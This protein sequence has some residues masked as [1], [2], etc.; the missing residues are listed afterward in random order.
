[1]ELLENRE[2]L[3]CRIMFLLVV[4]LQGR[5]ANEFMQRKIFGRPPTGEQTVWS[6]SNRRKM[7]PPSLLLQVIVIK[8]PIILER[9]E[10]LM[11]LH[12]VF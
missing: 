4:V 6:I 11:V 7:Q 2:C 1:M 5:T 3:V 9:S 8:D 12:A 10:F